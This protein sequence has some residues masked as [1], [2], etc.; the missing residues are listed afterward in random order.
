MLPLL[1]VV[2]ATLLAGACEE[3]ID[4]ERKAVERG[5]FGEEVHEI[6]LRDLERSPVRGRERA[7]V[8][9]AQR[10]TVVAAIDSV[11]P[12]ELLDPVDQMMIRIMP[13]YDDGMIPDLVRKLA[14]VLD[15]A[16]TERELLAT[17]ERLDR[18]PDYLSDPDRDELIAHLLRF[19]AMQELNRLLA[20]LVLAHDGKSDDGDTPE[21]N[22]IIQLLLAASVSLQDAEI[23]ND[24]ERFAATLVDVLLSEDAT[25]APAAGHT[26][27]HVV[28][29]DSRGLPRVRPGEL[30]A[31]PY[32]FV[33]RDGDQLADVDAFDRFV[34]AS[35]AVIEAATPFGSATGL[36]LVRDAQ[37]LLLNPSAGGTAFEY[38]DLH[39]TALG[40]LLR[41]AT[42]LVVADVPFDLLR[43]LRGLLGSAVVSTDAYGAWRGYASDSELVALTQGLLTALDHDDVPAVL[44]GLA[45]LMRDHPDQLAGVLRAFESAQDI[46]DRHDTDGY[47][48]D[49]TLLDDLLPLV[50]ELVETPGLLEA[51][52]IAMDDPVARRMGEA[53]ALLMRTSNP[54]I[55]IEKGGPYDACFYECRDTHPIGTVERYSCIRACP[56]DEIFA[57]VVDRDAPES[58]NN[59]SLFQRVEALMWE[60]VDQPYAVGVEEFIVNGANF[61]NTAQALGPAMIFEDLAEAYL[62]TLIG[63]LRLEDVINPDIA[64]LGQ[65][66]GLDGA[67]VVD[68]VGWIS[69]NILDVPLDP[70]PSTDQVTRFFNLSPV[71][72]SGEDAYMR[73]TPSVCKSGRLCIDAHADTLLAV[74]ASGM[75]DTMV[76]LVRAF[77]AHGKT[78]LLARLLAVVF[79]HYGSR[80]VEYLDVDG[81]P[82]SFPRSNIR[83]LEP[84]LIEI[85]EDGRLMSALA[86]QG[87]ILAGLELADGSLF[88]RALE[89]H[90]SWV[91]AP[92]ATLRLYDGRSAALDPAGRTV[93]PLSP[94][95]LVLDPLRAL[96]DVLASDAEAEA[97][98]ERATEAATDLLLETV[99]D[100]AVGARFARPGGPVLAAIV[101]ERLRATW[102]A[103]DAAGNRSA[104]LRAG[105]ARD[106][107]DLFAGRALFAGIELFGWLEQEPE[108]LELVRAVALHALQSSSATPEL[109]AIATYGL[110]TTGLDERAAVTTGRFL[111]RVIDP[112]RV[113]PVPGHQDLAL[114]LHAVLLLD[115]TLPLDP[116]AVMLDILANAVARHP[117]GG[118]SNAAALWDALSQVNRLE[119]GAAT[120]LAAA[121]YAEMLRMT[122][123]FLR[124]DARGM[125][126]L[127]DFIAF[128]MHG[129]GG[130]KQ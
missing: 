118:E 57:G 74:E 71:E 82:L 46:A 84:M 59:I 56:N 27:L 85:L 10:D 115:A 70:R 61:S 39:A 63:E 130:A 53:T 13:L 52:L 16:A 55:V 91:L 42:P 44:E 95:Y 4:F 92:D 110:L 32:P 79:T 47:A 3:P 100:G 83:S 126:R 18:R 37:G 43:A 120:P 67:T 9:A 103:E 2:A 104:W 96:S 35:G 113:W 14:V 88:V 25:F 6:L 36:G 58:A 48:D 107:G 45:R 22:A 129:P 29:V 108:R 5:T 31:V 51:L 50:R 121:D 20:E 80:A 119:P 105:P 77:H 49:S 69:V 102:L 94:L 122:A 7:E 12:S 75:A 106:L 30:D 128:A 8:F 68:I 28:R 26:P 89:R 98:W 123:E 125:E 76:P 65:P 124:D 112:R 93:A 73:M 1:V 15:E 87:P 78:D 116:D 86:D 90:L 66:L 64:A 127:Y 101:L 11:L 34:D 21:S 72:G 97:A 109:L 117:A 114:V 62:L 33:D 81:N 54:F 38:V 17:F 60:S 40:F 99:D 111:G 23:S 41:E 19:D 24:P